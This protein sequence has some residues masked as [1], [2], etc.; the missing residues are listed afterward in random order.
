MLR[1]GL[2]SRKVHENRANS[3]AVHRAVRMNFVW[4]SETIL[5]KSNRVV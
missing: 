1:K 4:G 2:C 5:T 3:R